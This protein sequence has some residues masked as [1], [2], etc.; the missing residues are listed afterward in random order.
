MRVLRVWNLR[1]G[2]ADDDRLSPYA[3]GLHRLFVSVLFEFNYLKAPVGFLLL[4]IGP[5]LIVGV[6][7]SL[8]ATYWQLL[9]HTGTLAENWVVIFVSLVV[10]LGI[11]YWIGRP[12]FSKIF[13]NFRHLQ[14]TLVFPIFVALR[15]LL[16]TGA[17]RLCGSSI[18]AEQLGRIRQIATALAAL[19]FAAA[20]LILAIRVELSFGLKLVN[21]EQVRVWAVVRAALGN[22]AVI[23]GLSTA[24]ESLHWFWREL[25]LGGPALDWVPEPLPAPS[26]L[27][28]IAHLSDLHIVGERYGY[29]MEAGTHGPRGNRCFRNTLRKLA[30]IHAK[31]P[32][33]SVLVTGDMT[34]AG[35]RAEWADFLD[36][37]RT[38]PDLQRRLSFVPGNHDVNIVDRSNPGR[39]DLPWSAGQGLRKLRFVLALD[40]VE[41]H[42]VHLVDRTCGAL[43]PSLKDFLR[44]D[45]RLQSLRMLAQTGSIR[46]RWAMAKAW[47]AIFPLVQLPARDEGCGLV[48]LDSNAA[49]HFSLTN[50]I[51]VISPTQLRALKALLRNFPRRAW[52]ILLHHSLVEYPDTSIRLKDRIGLALVNAPDVLAA[53]TPYA[54][55]VIVLHGHRH[56]DWIGTWRNLV[57]SSAPSTTLGSSGAEMRGSLHILELAL[58]GEGGIRLVKAERIEVT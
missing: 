52:I 44:A 40:A 24:L 2:D 49:S 28:R 22:A 56:V 39:L 1:R 12:L 46:G 33:D 13:V 11:A 14:Y 3:A 23:L 51:G 43:G 16:R 27:L 34:D 54:S 29:R 19:L 17:E 31:T 42:R 8:V 37:L 35:T 5:A 9:S 32:L 57:L 4:I 30:A 50:A 6:A 48:L 58:P 18:T 7:P 45:N 36:I 20:G 38:Y 26:L 15:E 55:N 10:L 53:I 47:D 21:V 41:G 25:T